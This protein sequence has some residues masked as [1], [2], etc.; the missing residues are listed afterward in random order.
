MSSEAESDCLGEGWGYFI[1]LGRL[2]HVITLISQDKKYGQK[3]PALFKLHKLTEP[4]HV[5]SF[6]GVLGSILDF[7]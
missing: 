3:A 4:T 2:L 6:R 5:L 1:A 7:N